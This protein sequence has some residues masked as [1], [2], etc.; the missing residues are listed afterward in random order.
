VSHS[1]HERP[2]VLVVVANVKQF[3]VVF[4]TQLAARLASAGIEL[5]VAYSDS[6]VAEALKGDSVELPA[7]LGVK[8]PRW[9][10]MAGRLLLQRVRLAELRR[11]DLII[12]EQSNGYLLNYPL[13]LAARLGLMRVAFW[14]HGYNHQGAPDA[15]GERLRRRFIVLSD[16]WFSYTQHTADYLRRNGVAPERITVINNATDTTAF[17]AEVAAVAPAEV[18]A[19]QERLA[20]PERARIGLYCGSLYGHKRIP[21]LLDAC[22]RIQQ[23]LPDFILAVAGAGESAERLREAARCLPWLR[24]L[25]PQFGHTKAVLFRSAEVFLN[26]GLVG[27]AILD[28]FAA[29]LPFIT[30]DLPIHSPEIAY[31]EPGVNGLMLPYATE[32]WAEAVIALLRDRDRL[33]TM[34]RAASRASRE[35]T[36]ERMTENVAQGIE[37]CLGMGAR[38]R[39]ADVG[40]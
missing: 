35:Y 31:L 40:G 29:G 20:L 22:A 17:A 5:R 1:R 34:S 3:R 18:R 2:T 8:V 7:P 15:I 23:Q 13:L 36:V 11:A 14:G 24:Y 33:V 27:L 10:F 21:F 28:S 30:S 9:Y 26:P 19:L 32:P 25:G 37:R 4:Y 6:H 16:W 38:A 39:G 12:T